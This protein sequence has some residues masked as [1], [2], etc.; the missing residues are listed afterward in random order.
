MRK[1][2]PCSYNHCILITNVLNTLP[3]STCPSCSA[4]QQLHGPFLCLSE[5]HPHWLQSQKK[6][7]FSQWHTLHPAG[8]L[9]H[10]L[11]L[12]ENF[13]GSWS[14]C[15]PLIL[16]FL[17]F[18]HSASFYLHTCFLLE[19]PAPPSLFRPQQRWCSVVTPCWP[20]EETANCTIPSV[21][22]NLSIKLLSVW[23]LSR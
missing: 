5:S 1:V 10:L 17:C 2:M 7:S 9:C 22:H 21:Q 11:T 3:P 20:M 8:E 15:I 6:F 16:G 12:P 19:W 23:S 14:S 13:L 18:S 4:L